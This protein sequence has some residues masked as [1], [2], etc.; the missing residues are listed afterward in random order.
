MN[1][2]LRKHRRYTICLFLLYR[3][4]KKMNQT[5]QQRKYW[6]HPILQRKQ[7]QGDCTI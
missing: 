4:I 7:Q 5:V 6:I 2:V 1:E 3:R